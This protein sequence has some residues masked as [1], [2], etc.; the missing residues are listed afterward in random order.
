MRYHLISGRMAIIKSL[1]TIKV[2][3]VWR[4]RSPLILLMGMQTS[5]TP[6]ESG[7]ETPQ[8]RNK[9]TIQLGNY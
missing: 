8:N 9:T 7:M 4:N 2:E 5:L 1:Q 3:R 6:V